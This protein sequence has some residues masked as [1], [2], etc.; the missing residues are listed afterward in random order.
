[1]RKR[2]RNFENELKSTR[3]ELE[4]S[5][6]I[7]ES[8]ESQISS[9]QT[10]LG[11]MTISNSRLQSKELELIALENEFEIVQKEMKEIQTNCEKLERDRIIWEKEEKSVM[12]KE[13]IRLKD[14]LYVLEKAH[15]RGLFVFVF[16][17]KL[18][19]KNK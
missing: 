13:M 16:N 3:E 10:Q 7:G 11:E 6:A 15:A 2:R 1:M 14:R 5:V 9:I 17:G 19:N 8:L 18:M 4:A 12:E